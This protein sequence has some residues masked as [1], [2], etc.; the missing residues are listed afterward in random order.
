MN[1]HYEVLVIGGGIIG[2]SIS[3]YLNKSGV[4]AIV[5][6]KHTSARKSTRAAAG[7][8]GVHTENKT[9]GIYHQFCMTSRD[10]YQDL[11]KELSELTAIDIGL[12][13]VGMIEIAVDHGQKNELLSKKTSFPNLEWLEGQQLRD[14]IPHLKYALGALYMKEDGHVEPTNVCEAF[15]KAALSY[16]GELVENN[17]VLGIEKKDGVFTIKSENGLL[18]A[19]K[20]VVAS[21]A[22]S[23]WWF[24]STGLKNP[25]VP[26]KGECFSIKP[27]KNYFKEALFLNNFYIVPKPDGR[28]I[29]GATSKPNDQSVTT[30]AG[31]L[32]S[33]MN[34]VFSIFPDLK[35]ES[36]QDYWS[37]IRPGST[38][39]FP[40]IG[41]HPTLSGFFFA[42]G[43]YRN[44]ILLAPATGKMI[45]DLIV[46][47]GVHYQSFQDMFSPN[48]FQIQGGTLYE[49]LR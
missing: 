9:S 8:L 46:N 25:M 23:G 1:E 47:R 29:V 2:H 37:G 11:S 10:L 17:T 13:L 15:K 49:Y 19:E 3:Y 16:G 5:V 33:L 26:T 4:P 7:M 41:E 32:S 24:E 6:E 39:G 43:H 21:G 40:I 34:Q 30:T 44:G 28:Y 36:F 48:R 14:R 45:K 12:S 31:G 20:V 38:D 42:T 35:E 27:R 18:T 22:D